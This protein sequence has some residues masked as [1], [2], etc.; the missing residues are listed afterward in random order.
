MKSLMTDFLH[1]PSLRTLNAQNQ[2][3]HYMVEADGGVIPMACPS[4]SC[5]LYRHGSQR[6]SCMDTPM[7]GK[8]QATSRLITYIEFHC[9]KK[10]FADL[11]REIG[12]DDKTIRHVFD[13]YVARKKETVHFETPEIPGVDELKIIG[14]YRAMVTNVGKLSMYDMLPTRNKADLDDKAREKLADCSTQ[15]PMMKFFCNT[16]STE[17]RYETMIEEQTVLYGAC[18]PTLVRKLEAGEFA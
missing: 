12:V 6:Q 7:H 9:T 16:S 15:H 4:C 5:T 14:Q 3:S 17:Q 18:I 1:L 11:S 8:R 10:T 13:D 2:G